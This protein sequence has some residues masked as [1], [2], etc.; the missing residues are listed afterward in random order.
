LALIFLLG[1][2]GSFVRSPGEAP[3][4]ILLGAIVPLVVFGVAYWG[5]RAFRHRFSPPIFGS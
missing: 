5:W 4:P 3:I 1:A 2:N